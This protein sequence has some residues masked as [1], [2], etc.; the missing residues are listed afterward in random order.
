[1]RSPSFSRP[2]GRPGPDQAGAKKA[3]EPAG[4][5]LAWTVSRRPDQAEARTGSA[6]LLRPLDAGVGGG[7]NW[8]W[9][10][11]AA[12]TESCSVFYFLL[13]LL[14]LLLLLLCQN[15]GRPEMTDRR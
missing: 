9:R 1:M 13:V 12:E 3:G 2:A 6:G 4:R 15:N 10:R 14:L 7:R 8:G 5:G 11:A